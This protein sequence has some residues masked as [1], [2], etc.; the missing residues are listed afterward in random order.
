MKYHFYIGEG[1]DSESFIAEVLAKESEVEAA[2]A[3]VIKEYN[4]DGLMLSSFYSDNGACLG[5][6]FK[7]KQNLPFLKGG[8]NCK[9]LGYA[10]YPK[11]N[12]K[13]GKLLDEKL[14]APSMT[15]SQSGY[16]MKSLNLWRTVIGRH[17]ASRTGFAMHSSTAGI[18]NGKLLVRIPRTEERIPRDDPMPEIPS[19]LREV[20][21]SEFLAAQ[22]K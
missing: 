5:L 22:G 7:E 9:D 15:F 1:P 8:K 13:A 18:I 4:A 17:P 21:E 6:A 10:Y 11:L 20:K 3:A 14:K 19:F 2:R 12:C 16:I